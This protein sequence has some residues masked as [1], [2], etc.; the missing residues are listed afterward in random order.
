MVQGTASILVKS[1][2]S[3]AYGDAAFNLGATSNSDAT[4]VYSSE[5]PLIASVDEFGEVT[6]NGVGTCKI[7]LSQV[8][9]TNYTSATTHTTI[10]VVQKTASILVKSEFSV[11]YDAPPF[12]LN[13]TS[14]SGAPIIYTSENELIAM[15][16]ADGLVT[17]TGIVGTCKINLSQDATANYTGATTNTTIIVSDLSKNVNS[18][19]RNANLFRSKLAKNIMQ[20][21][22]QQNKPVSFKM[23]FN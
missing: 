12:N 7:T 6:I 9:T 8:E 14:N 10:I 22:K 20:I 3:V 16:D 15:V 2:F 11:V 5:F 17:I 18:V 1:E 21:P 19:S 13:A 23:V 4:I